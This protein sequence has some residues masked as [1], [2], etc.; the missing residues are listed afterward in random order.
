[1]SPRLIGICKVVKMALNYVNR[2]IHLS[3]DVDAL[4]PSVASNAG[5]VWWPYRTSVRRSMRLAYL[6]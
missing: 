6:T 2:R 5:S 3:F 1:M 4:D